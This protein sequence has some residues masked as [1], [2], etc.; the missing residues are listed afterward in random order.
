MWKCIIKTDTLILGTDYLTMNNHLFVRLRK[1]F[2]YITGLPVYILANK[3]FLSCS[4]MQLYYMSIICL[5]TVQGIYHGIIIYLT[6]LETI[7]YVHTYNIVFIMYFS[8]KVLLSCCTMSIT[9]LFTDQ[10]IY[11]RN[12]YLSDSFRENSTDMYHYDQCW[13]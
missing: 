12:N 13:T 10:G 4:C 1:N 2:E 11:Q 5:F 9:C 7:P 8:Y 3:V 6:D